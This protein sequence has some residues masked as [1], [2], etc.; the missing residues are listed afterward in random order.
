MNLHG[1]C[2]APAFRYHL[3]STYACP[4]SFPRPT[5]TGTPIAGSSGPVSPNPSPVPPAKASL[6]SYHWAGCAG[7]AGRVSG[8]AAA[9]PGYFA[10]LGSAAAGGRCCGHCGRGAGE[11]AQRL[12]RERERAGSRPH[13]GDAVGHCLAGLVAGG[14]GGHGGGRG[15]SD[16]PGAGAGR[17]HCPVLSGGR[18]SRHAGGHWHY[19]DSEADSALPWGR[20]RLF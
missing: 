15:Y 1:P 4:T 8:S 18:Y 7:G 17:H 5:R 3:P 10:G 20:Y 9:V 6:F 13:G 16:G 12:G 14:A 11:P 2:S 19:S